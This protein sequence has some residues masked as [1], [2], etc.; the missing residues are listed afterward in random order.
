MTLIITIEMN[1]SAFDPCNGAGAARILHT[2]ADRLNY[3]R[4]TPD[5][6]CNLRD[7]NGNPVGTAE[8]AD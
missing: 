2:L 4:L 6:G 8:I 7:I 3:V 1:N 5:D